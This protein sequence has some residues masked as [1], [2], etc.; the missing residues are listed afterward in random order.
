MGGHGYAVVC[1]TSDMLETE[2]VCI[3]RPLERS[4]GSDGGLIVYRSKH[5]ARLWRKGDTPRLETQILE[6]DPKFSV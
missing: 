3:P 1:V 4:E 5:R 6:G 2:F